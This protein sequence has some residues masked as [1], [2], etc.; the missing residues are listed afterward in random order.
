[1][2]SKTEFSRDAPHE[3]NIELL[4]FCRMS[5]CKICEE[6]SLVLEVTLNS[7]NTV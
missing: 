4:Q 5:S 1:M 3:L 6:G 2:V 7:V